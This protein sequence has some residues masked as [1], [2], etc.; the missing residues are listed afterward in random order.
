MN[1]FTSGKSAFALAVILIAVLVSCNTKTKD[2]TVEQ[3]AALVRECEEVAALYRDSIKLAED[4]ATV[5][6]LFDA[7]DV[8]LTT[9][10]YKYAPDLYLHISE[11]QNEKIAALIL[12]AVELRD[13]IL[14]SFAHQQQ[15]LSDSVQTYSMK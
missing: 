1:P 7:M 12:R 8:A 9:V 6:R 3:T 15:V 13:S 5:L 14:Y 11:S 4:S 10:N 2:D